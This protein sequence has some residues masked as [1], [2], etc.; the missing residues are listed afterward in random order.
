MGDRCPACLK[1]CGQPKPFVK[2]VARAPE[3]T[4]DCDPVAT[5]SR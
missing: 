2:K 1:H 4:N 5:L 3:L